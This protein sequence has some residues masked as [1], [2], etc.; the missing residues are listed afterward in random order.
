MKDWM[1]SPMVTMVSSSVN[2]HNI[3]NIVMTLI[4]PHAMTM[5]MTVRLNWMAQR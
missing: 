5:P 4:A 2:L 3:A 1:P